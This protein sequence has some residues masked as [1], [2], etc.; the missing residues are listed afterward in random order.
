MDERTAT[1]DE[2]PATIQTTATIET[3]ATNETPATNANA[4]TIE[5]PA[6]MDENATTIKTPATNENATTI[7]NPETMDEN[8]ETMEE[9]STD[10]SQEEIETAMLRGYFDA[11]L[12]LFQ[13]NNVCANEGCNKRSSCQ[14]KARCD[15]CGYLAHRACMMV[16]EGDSTR[17]FCKSCIKDLELEVENGK[18]VNAGRWTEVENNRNLKLINLAPG[19]Y[20][21]ATTAAIRDGMNCI[22]DDDYDPTNN[23]Y[24]EESVSSGDGGND[25]SEASFNHESD[26]DEDEDVDLGTSEDEKRKFDQ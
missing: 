9:R 24:Q 18:A 6:T 15:F 1:M 23:N 14:S 2:S 22:P 13:R 19:E 12:V 21:K 16:V 10:S 5:T 3:T 20:E 7:E 11:G 17:R 26:D 8:P 4:T 25:E